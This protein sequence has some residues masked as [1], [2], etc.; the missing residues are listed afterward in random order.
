MKTNFNL[1][2]SALLV[3]LLVLII[4]LVVKPKECFLLQGEKRL[5]DYSLKELQKWEVVYRD[6]MNVVN[7]NAY[8]NLNDYYDRT[9][10]AR[11]VDKGEDVTSCKDQNGNLYD[12]EGQARVNRAIATLMI[13][14]PLITDDEKVRFI[15]KQK[16]K[17]VK[18][19]REGE[20]AELTDEEIVN[21]RNRVNINAVAHN[22]RNYES[23]NYKLITC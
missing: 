1:I 3:V 21:D 17:N 18:S 10:F 5:S 14:W 20:I 7:N 16:E 22:T 23:D 15:N 13:S 2:H 11:V 4:Y 8:A 6:V 19:G 9:C 12:K